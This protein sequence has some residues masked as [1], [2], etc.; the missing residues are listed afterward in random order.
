MALET[1]R[2][3]RV[4]CC[5]AMRVLIFES[6]EWQNFLWSE[7]EGRSNHNHGR[8]PVGTAWSA[9][10]RTSGSQDE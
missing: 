2:N 10:P 8:V 9:S 4:P 5:F 1:V 6:S 3:Q 7:F